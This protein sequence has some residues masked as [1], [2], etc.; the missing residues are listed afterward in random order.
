MQDN[1]KKSPLMATA[2]V[3]FV[4]AVLAAFG[5]GGN[6]VC[7][8]ITP[9]E[10][11]VV[12]AQ[13]EPQETVSPE[14]E[15]PS[16]NVEFQNI[17]ID[18]SQL[19]E[20]PLI[21]VNNTYI[22]RD[23]SDEGLSNLYSD[24]NC[25]L[26][27]LMNSSVLTD[28]LMMD[29]LDEMFTDFDKAVDTESLESSVMVSYGYRS[30]ELQTQWYYEDL[31]ATGLDYS[32][33]V[34]K[35]G[36][37]EHHTGLAVD[38]ALY[39]GIVLDFDGTDVYSWIPENCFK[40]GLIQ[41]YQEEKSDITGIMYEPWHYRYIGLPHSEIVTLNDICYEEYIFGLKSYTY[42]NPYVYKCETDGKEYMIY[43]VE[44][45]NDSNNVIVPSNAEFSISGNNIDGV[46][47][48]AEL[49]TG[50]LTEENK[51]FSSD[52][53]ISSQQTTIQSEETSSDSGFDSSETTALQ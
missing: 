9:V 28:K 45:Y 34:A 53:N 48:T 17:S 23:T 39:N 52:D 6:Y 31:A 11:V 42:D 15:I 32:Q 49:E 47:V 46:I 44:C 14:P 2:E 50:T 38:L 43:Y 27:S 12:T 25:I 4:I 33:K 8:N 18:K 3:I 19:F 13:A 36:Y 5:I 26:Y 24:R 22:C 10:D 7:K 29:S 30:E 51:P 37:S 35:P 40:Y 41:R 1:Y 21:L 20:G 16:Y